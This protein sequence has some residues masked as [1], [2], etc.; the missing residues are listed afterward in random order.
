LNSVSIRDELDL[1]AGAKVGDK[2]LYTSLGDA[3]IAD[4]IRKLNPKTVTVTTTYDNGKLDTSYF[5]A[6]SDRYEYSVNFHTVV[7][8]YPVPADSDSILDGNLGV[9]VTIYFDNYG[10]VILVEPA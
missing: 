8:G 7:D 4:S 6:G 5:K 1:P 10:K 9:E 2:V 3:I